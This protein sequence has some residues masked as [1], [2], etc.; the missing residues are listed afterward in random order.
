MKMISMRNR[1][2]HAYFTWISISCGRRFR[3]I[4]RRC[5]RFLRLLG[6]NRSVSFR[7]LG[8]HILA[9]RNPQS[10]TTSL[11]R[12]RV[13]ATLSASLPLPAGKGWPGQEGFRADGPQRS[14]AWGFRRAAA[15]EGCDFPGLGPHSFRRAN[16][17]CRQEVGASSIE[18]S[19][20]GG[21]PLKC[22]C[23]AQQWLFETR[24]VRL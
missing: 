22:N 3:K 18:A 12:I 1:L 10:S 9:F 23:R 15:D 17:T 13:I 14:A 19:K 4:W 2:I 5:C 21:G 11:N 24:P 7:S 8:P 6:S 20:T 16:V